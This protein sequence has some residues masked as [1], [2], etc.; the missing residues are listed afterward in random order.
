MYD[1]QGTSPK[2]LP[3]SYRILAEA[4]VSKLGSCDK[5]PTYCQDQNVDTVLMHNDGAG[6]E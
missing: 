2:A 6:N 4:K 5:H 3:L 1:L